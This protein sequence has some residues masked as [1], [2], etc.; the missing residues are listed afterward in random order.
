MFN[1]IPSEYIYLDNAASSPLLSSLHEDL[2]AIFKQGYINPSSGHKLG[3]QM[4]KNLD[5]IKEEFLNNSVGNSE[6]D[7]IWTSGGTESN[8]LAILGSIPDNRPLNYHIVS[9]QTEHASVDACLDYLE[10]SGARV[11]RISVDQNGQLNL[12][13]LKSCLT[14]ETN[15]LSVA[16]VQSETGVIQDLGA[17]RKVLDE[18]AP[19]ALLHVD[20]VQAL[21]KVSIPW[22]DTRIDLI[23][24]SGHKIHGPGSIGALIKR[25]GIDLKPQILGGGQQDNYRS[26]SLDPANIAM[27]N[28]ALKVLS[29]NSFT[30]K[31]AELKDKLLDGLKK[32]KVNYRLISPEQ[33]SPFILNLSFPEYQGAILMRF[34]SEENI[35]IGTG[36]A[37]ASQS[38]GPSK[39]LIAMGCTKDEAF[40]SIRISF[41]LQNSLEDVDKFLTAF[42]SVLKNY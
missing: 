9:S 38:S 21:G 31:A 35:M 39:T 36:S 14:A 5:R 1:S 13:E 28:A 19:K 8:N 41:G 27:F 2:P 33:S 24:F 22:Q 10:S 15:F 40:G 3:R 29:E 23:S 26:G 11:D 18:C 4:T 37:C 30:E 7:L 42:N 12:D 25:P 6:A 32:L 20:A 16:L 34:L 17:I